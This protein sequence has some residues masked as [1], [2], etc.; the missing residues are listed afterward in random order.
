MTVRNGSRREDLRWSI[1]SLTEAIEFCKAEGEDYTVQA[2]KLAASQAELRMLEANGIDTP[3]MATATTE[4]TGTARRLTDRPQ[5]GSAASNQYG[6]FAV[7]YASAKQTAFIKSLMDRKDLRPLADSVTIDVERLR[8]QVAATQVN[9][10]A[11]SAIIDRLLALPDAT[12]TPAGDPAPQGRPATDNQYHFITTL[13]NERELT[14][15]DRAKVL[16]AVQGKTL[17]AKGASATIEKLLALPKAAV[18]TPAG[19]VEAGVYVNPDG[20]V[21]RVYL[22]QQSGKMLAA[23]AIRHEDGSAEF[24]YQGQADRYITAASRKMTLEEAAAWGKATGTCIVCARR[25]DVPESVDRGIG[26]VCYAK[27]GG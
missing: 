23:L 16:A 19:P 27:M 21:F 7:C 14:A 13:A 6:T 3:G 5:A 15:E 20:K 25:L 26:P 1:K 4:G 8:E 11:A 12:A 10:K 22:G 24:D 18:T 2:A 9:K 17:S